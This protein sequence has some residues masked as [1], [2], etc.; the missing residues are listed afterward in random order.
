MM[1]KEKDVLEKLY[2]QLDILDKHPDFNES[3]TTLC[4]VETIQAIVQLQ[5][6]TNKAIADL[7]AIRDSTYRSAVTLR[8]KVD[9]VISGLKGE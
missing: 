5:K 4:V 7:T 1:D 6:R 3:C 2:E 9:M 8:S